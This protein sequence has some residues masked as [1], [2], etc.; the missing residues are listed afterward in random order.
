MTITQHFIPNRNFLPENYFRHQVYILRYTGIELVKEETFWY[1]VYSKIIL[2]ITVYTYTCVEGY[3]LY[4]NWG[5]LNAITNVLNYLVTHIIG[6]IK[7]TFLYV[8]RYRF[9]KMIKKLH[10]G[11]F[12]PN[13]NRGGPAEEDAIKRVVFITE[14]A[15]GLLIKKISQTH[16]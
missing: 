13:V 6:T 4:A 8:H 14:V 11:L 1:S 9:K 16:F 12:A 10:E 3:E 2:F 15:V 5:D 7:I